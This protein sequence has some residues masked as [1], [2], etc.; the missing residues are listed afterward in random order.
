[1]KALIIDD[2]KDIRELISLS[3]DTMDIQCDTAKDVSEALNYLNNNQ[4]HFCITDLNLPDGNGIDIVQFVQHNHPNLPIAVITAYGDMNTAV[5][6]MKAGAFDFIAK[7]IDLAILRQ[8][9]KN[10]LKQEKTTSTPISNKRTKKENTINLLGDS[11]VMQNLKTKINKVARSLAP[12]HIYGES[13]TGKELVAQM[14][15]QQSARSEQAFVPI[16]CGA[17]PNELVESELFGHKKGSFTGAMQDKVGLFKEADG[18]TLFLDEIAE[19]P[20]LMQVKLLRA[21]Q[22]KKIR[23]VGS[24][25]EEAIN[26]RVISASHKNLNDAVTQGTFR[27]DLYYR[28]NVIEIVV[29]PLRERQEDIPLLITFFLQKIAEELQVE[30]PQIEDS[31][32][33]QLT[34]YSFEGNVRELENI[35]QRAIT[36]CED[37]IINKHDLNL[38]VT[39]KQTTALL[40]LQEI[41]KN[42]EI[43]M[44][45]TALQK[46]KWNQK[47]AAKDL[48]LTYRQLR[49]K[50]DK[51]G[52]M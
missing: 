1:M 43:E 33:Q 45:Q 11:S 36:L 5:T 25:T 35:L 30:P 23:P 51:L 28:I 16:N 37:N 10:A 6:A 44:I 9:A 3:F 31:A 13:G 48:G 40:N 34:Q 39:Q 29:P 15:H 27:Q 32:L 14:I 7:P 18:G 4:Y 19:L 17:L 20:I 21:L 12:I 47:R 8:T 49:Y 38:K 52:L 41:N 26:V 22:E 24:A 50:V 46:H 42:T 2:E